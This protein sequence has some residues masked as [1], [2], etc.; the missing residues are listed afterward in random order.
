MKHNIGEKREENRGRR[1]REKYHRDSIDN[2]TRFLRD[3]Q[4]GEK[5]SENDDM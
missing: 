2:P 5:K 3:L 4:D 1:E